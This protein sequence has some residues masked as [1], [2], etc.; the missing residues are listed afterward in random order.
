M[1][2]LPTGFN[3][4][5]CQESSVGVSCPG[6]WEPLN[7]QELPALKQ[8]PRALGNY[9]E[10]ANTPTVTLTRMQKNRGKVNLCS[11]CLQTGKEWPGPQCLCSA[12]QTEPWGLL[13]IKAGQRWKPAPEFPFSHALA[14]ATVV[15]NNGN[16]AEL[17]D[18]IRPARE[19]HLRNLPSPAPANSSFSFGP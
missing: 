10:R 15:R 9:K 14:A 6:S 4:C 19:S 18:R 7:S 11:F 1:T 3:S 13:R 8:T 12:F 17:P 5:C 2:N 16:Q